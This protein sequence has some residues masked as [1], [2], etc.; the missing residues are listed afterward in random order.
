[1]RQ[2]RTDAV[3]SQVVNPE[4]FIS[5]N[6]VG[7]GPG[8]QRNSDVGQH[9]YPHYNF[10]IE[11]ILGDTINTVTQ[12][13]G[14]ID[15]RPGHQYSSV[16]ETECLLWPGANFNA[17]QL[18]LGGRNITTHDTTFNG[19]NIACRFNSRAWPEPSYQIDESLIFSDAPP[20]GQC[21]GAT[22]NL[23]TPLQPGV[24]ASDLIFS[25]DFE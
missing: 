15:L 10:L 9:F 2:I 23:P 5:G 14:W 8:W 4:N 17:T 20:N 18:F 1:L 12:D 11:N 3:A 7:D 19:A 13:A 16:F 24:Y 22:R 21:N 25:N 6:H